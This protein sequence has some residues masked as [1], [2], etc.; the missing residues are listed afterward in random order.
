MTNKMLDNI[1]ILVIMELTMFNN[2]KS[3]D[4]VRLI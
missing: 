4:I 3:L 2:N 1:T